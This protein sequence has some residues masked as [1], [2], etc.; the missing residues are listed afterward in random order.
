M[1]NILKVSIKKKDH[2]TLK[3]NHIM[4]NKNIISNSKNKIINSKNKITYNKDLFIYK[5]NIEKTNKK[6]KIE[7]VIQQFNFNKHRIIVEDSYIESKTQNTFIIF[8][9][10]YDILTLVY[11]N[12]NNNNNIITFNLVDFKKINEIKNNNPER[13]IIHLRHYQ[14]KKSNKDLILTIINYNLIE[15]FDITNLERLLTLKNIYE[16]GKIYSSC[17]IEEKNN[18]YV[19]TSNESV[20]NAEGIKVFDFKGNMIK[21]IKNSFFSTYFIDFYFDEKSSTNFIITGN[22]KFIRSYN[23]DKNIFYRKYYE[24]NILEHYNAVIF[25][26]NDI[27]KMMEIDTDGIVR[28]WNFHSGNLI[29]KIETEKQLSG[30]YLWD[31]EFLFIGMNDKNVEIFEINEEKLIYCFLSNFCI[32]KMEKIEHPNLGKCLLAQSKDKILLYNN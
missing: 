22:S 16:N 32:L 25:E 18:I 14:C 23:Y 21:S 5:N 6:N 31:K 20:F 17:F 13:K 4:N 8:N 1:K 29:K 9:S 27:V 28:I 26:K 19:L 12:N 7:E 30:I 15:I 24:Y 10:V 2:F 3:K 11:I